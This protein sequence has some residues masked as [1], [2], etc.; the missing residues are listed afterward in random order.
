MENIYLT[1]INY[2]MFKTKINKKKKSAVLEK[3]II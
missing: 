3:I 1:A 2:V